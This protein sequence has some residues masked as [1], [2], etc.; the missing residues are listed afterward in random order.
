MAGAIRSH[1]LEGYRRDINNHI[2]PY[3]GQKQLTK[4]TPADLKNLYAA[5]LEHGRI[6]KGQS[7]NHGLAPAAVH[8][9]HTILHH[10]LKTAEAEGLLPANHAGQVTSPKVSNKPKRIL[11]NEQLDALMEVI[12]RDDLW[13]DFFYTEL[14]TGLRRGELCGLKW[15]DF[16]SEAGT[17][18]VCRTIIAQKGGNLAAGDTK[19]YAGTRTILLPHSTAQ[20]LK[21]RK[22]PALTEWIFPDL[23]RPERP[24]NPSSAYR[25]L[26]KLLAEA[27]L[28][29]I[30]FHDLRHTFATHALA[31][32]VDAKTLSGIL[33]HTKASFTLDIYAHVTGDM[34]R[35][36]ARVVGDFISD[37]I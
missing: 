19:T 21:A 24:T 35:H 37:I 3:L 23:L 9:I 10:A 1:T 12:R 28:P 30:R 2:R 8:G 32:G 20:L 18:K 14:T 27:G 26:K 31:G 33:G 15:E 36:A 7:S 11:D 34:Q 17:L 13:H 22:Q 6:T 29:D 4:I 25:K 5:L 16:D